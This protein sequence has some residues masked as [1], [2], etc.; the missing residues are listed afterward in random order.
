MIKRTLFVCLL[1]VIFSIDGYDV[2]KDKFKICHRI[3]EEAKWGNLFADGFAMDVKAAEI[4]EAKF[5]GG[6]FDHTL[7]SVIPGNYERMEKEWQEIKAEIAHLIGPVPVTTNQES[8]H[9]ENG[10][11]TVDELLADAH[12]LAP[13]FKKDFQEIAVQNRAVVDF[14]PEGGFIIKSKESLT[15]KVARDARTLKISEAEAISKIGDALRGTLIVDDPS[16]IAD[17]MASIEDYA[18]AHRGKVVFKNLWE[19]NRESGYVGI[20]A[21]LLLPCFSHGKVHYLMAEMQI[22]LD[23]IVDGTALSAKERTHS[24]YEFVREE[25]KSPAELSAASKLLFLAAMQELLDNLHYQI[26]G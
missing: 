11:K 18:A 25:G 14:G 15:S 23:S 17:L 8:A 5:D 10:S 21:K 22:H 7:Q 26:H 3:I 6:Y 2:T 1:S 20:H 12:S 13:I 4:A 19:E 24:I 9:W 16:R